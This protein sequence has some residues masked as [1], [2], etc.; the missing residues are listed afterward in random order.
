MNKQAVAIRHVAFEDLGLLET[1]LRQRGFDISYQDAWDLDP[2]AAEAADLT[3][4][5]GG[6]ISVND[7]E[8]YPFLDAEIA[9]TQTR[10][11]RGGPTLGLCLGAQI[12][13]KAIGGK[14]LTERSTPLAMA[15]AFVTSPRWAR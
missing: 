2:A 8:N 10:L 4:I 15:L 6:P 11:D 3:V 12:M 1:I 9:I 14:A 5:L 13:A 7:T